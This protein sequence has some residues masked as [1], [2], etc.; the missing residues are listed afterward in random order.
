MNTSILFLLSLERQLWQLHQPL[1]SSAGQSCKEQWLQTAAWKIQWYSY[2]TSEVEVMNP[3]VIETG[4]SCAVAERRT[5]HR[6]GTGTGLHQGWTWLQISRKVWSRV[7]WSNELLPKCRFCIEREAVPSN[8]SGAIFWMVIRTKTDT[9]TDALFCNRRE[10][11]CGA[12][13]QKQGVESRTLIFF[14]GTYPTLNI[15]RSCQH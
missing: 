8:K 9:V 2:F 7:L 13:H 5:Q 3:L 6:K 10:T 4:L 12:E 14:L 15:S 11:A 1:L